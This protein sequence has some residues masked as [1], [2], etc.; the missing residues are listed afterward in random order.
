MGEGVLNDIKIGRV[1][2]GKGVGSLPVSN[3][4]SWGAICMG[5]LCA[6]VKGIVQR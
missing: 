6:A 1:D 5:T 2:G 3:I 4:N